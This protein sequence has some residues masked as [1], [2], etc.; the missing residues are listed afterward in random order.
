MIQTDLYHCILI[1]VLHGG[2][3]QHCLVHSGCRV[4]FSIFCMNV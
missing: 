3:L 4:R 2:D 1:V